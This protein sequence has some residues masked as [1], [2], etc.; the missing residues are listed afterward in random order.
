MGPEAERKKEER[1]RRQ[2][3]EGHTRRDEIGAVNA[4]AGPEGGTHY[5]GGRR[6]GGTG[7][8]KN[9]LKESDK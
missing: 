9:M 1:S 2:V 6:L 8:R 7:R 4:I 3:D 5:S